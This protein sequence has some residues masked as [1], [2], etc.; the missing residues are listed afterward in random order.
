[1]RVR[2]AS[3]D[4]EYLRASRRA[5]GLTQGQL[6]E[7]AGLDVKTIR[8]AEQGRRLDLVTIR[9]LATTME[10]DVARLVR[11]EPTSPRL[12]PQLAT[13]RLK[14]LSQWRRAV[15]RGEDERAL[16]HYQD[17][18]ILRLPGAPML[19]AQDHYAGKE[20]IRTAYQTESQWITPGLDARSIRPLLVGD[21]EAVL[22]VN[23]I[24]KSSRKHPI[25]LPVHHWFRFS[26]TYIIEHNILFDTLRFLCCTKVI[27]GFTKGVPGDSAI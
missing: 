2:G 12:T 27:P 11:V 16:L 22:R 8:M 23:R 6:A 9:R 14:T 19:V 10:V 15:R 21:S 5:R 26:H 3:P 18:A 25:T 1:M 4:G 13:L 24:V 17:H 7:L 20:Q